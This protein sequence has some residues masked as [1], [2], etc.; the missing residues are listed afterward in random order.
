MKKIFLALDN[1]EKK[2]ILDLVK[3]LKDEVMFKINDS[4]TKFGPELIEEIHSL[5]GEVFLD[6]KFH[7][8]PNTVKNYSLTAA[9]KKVFVFNVHCMGGIEMMKQARKAVDEY[10]EKNNSRKPLIV[11]VTILTS[12]NEENLKKELKIDSSVEEMVKHLAL[13]AKKAGLDGAVCSPKEITLIKKACGKEFI[14]ICPGIR[15]KWSTKDDQKRITTPKQAVSDGA[16]Y[17][18]IGRPIIKAEDYGMTRKQAVKKII[19][20]LI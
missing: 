12:M 5:G 11:G 16:D 13:Q 20:E 1:M 8:I 10:S 19:Q 4:F 7:D 17:L 15:P 14:T 18:V 3:E 9:E 2:E 6:L